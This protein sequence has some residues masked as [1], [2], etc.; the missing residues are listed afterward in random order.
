MREESL[1]PVWKLRRTKLARARIQSDHFDLRTSLLEDSDLHRSCHP[2]DFLMVDNI[3]KI[4]L[5]KT[6]INFPPTNSIIMASTK[7]YQPTLKIKAIKEMGGFFHMT[8]HSHSRQLWCN[9]NLFFGEIMQPKEVQVDVE[10]SANLE[11]I[12]FDDISS[13]IIE[14]LSSNYD[15]LSAVHI[16]ALNF[17]MQLL[18]KNKFGR[19]ETPKV[20]GF[21]MAP[22]VWMSLYKLNRVKFH[23]STPLMG[24]SALGPGP[25][26]ALGLQVLTSNFGKLA[27]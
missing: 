25:V 18:L 21:W 7:S 27:I 3:S 16:G 5:L 20:H 12:N 10:T 13:M 23:F 1:F 15:Y 4:S 11:E 19:L 26:S 17:L 6:Y 9:A 14:L 8:Y 24:F 2:R 22:M